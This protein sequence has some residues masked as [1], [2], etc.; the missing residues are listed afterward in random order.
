VPYADLTP[1]FNTISGLFL[2]GEW[3]SIA[4]FIGIDMIAKSGFA[5]QYLNN[6]PGKIKR[7]IVLMVLVALIWR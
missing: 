5:L 6:C 1:L 2:L 7:G 4:G 3:P